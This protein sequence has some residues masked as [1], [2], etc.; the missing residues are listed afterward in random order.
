MVNS[1]MYGYPVFSVGSMIRKFES[2]HTPPEAAHRIVNIDFPTRINAVVL[3]QSKVA[4]NKEM[5]FP[6]GEILFSVG[7]FIKVRVTMIDAQSGGITFKGFIQ[8]EVLAKHAYDL[9]CNALGVSPAL[10]VEVDEQHVLKHSGLG[11][12]GAVLAAVC[13]AIN[14]MYDC[15][16]SDLELLQYIVGNY[17]EEVDDGNNQQLQCNPCFGGSISTGLFAGGIQILSGFATPIFE[18]NYDANVLIGIPNDYIP[19][20]ASEE[21]ARHA[22]YLFGD[23]NTDDIRAQ[24]NE[25]AMSKNIAYEVIHKVMPSLVHGDLS[26]LGK[27]SYKFSF[28][29]GSHSVNDTTWLYPRCNAIAKRISRLFTDEYCTVLGISS[30]GPAFYAVVE[31][32]R[33]EEE[34]LSLFESQHLACSLVPIYNNKYQVH[35]V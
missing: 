24:I 6:G 7:C 32:E 30:V 19:M 20:S 1:P 34:C 27:L 15:P 3:D 13:V 11:S 33:Q 2:K 22:Q 23:N 8:R 18:T 5:I 21:I 17:G 10:Q 16:I 31:N 25:T 28:G 26:E 29:N 14:E 35:Y 9:M 4:P 12:S